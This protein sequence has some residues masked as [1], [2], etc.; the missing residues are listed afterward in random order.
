MMGDVVRNDLVRYEELSVMHFRALDAFNVR[1]FAPPQPGVY[2]LA[3]TAS[4]DELRV[5]T[6]YFFGQTDNLFA[7]LNGHLRESDPALAAHE[8]LGNRWFRVV[9]ADLDKLEAELEALKALYAK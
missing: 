6:P 5:Q 8:A 7:A 9:L 4:H 3:H 1:E 2:A